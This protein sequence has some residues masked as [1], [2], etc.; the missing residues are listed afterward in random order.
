MVL[1]ATGDVLPQPAAGW[2]D[3]AEVVSVPNRSYAHAVNA[4]FAMLDGADL[5]T[6]MNDDVLVEPRTFADLL[7]ALAAHPG[8]GLS[9][10]I[11]LTAGGRPQDLGVPYR[12]AYARARKS[13]SGAAAVAWLAGCLVVMTRQAYVATGGLDETF[14]FTNE[15]LD[16]SLRARA[17]GYTSLL[18]DTE[19]THLGGTSTPRHPAFHV[20]GRRGGYLITQR[21]L[22]PVLAAAH[23]AYLVLEGGVGAL[24]GPTKSSRAAHRG[25]ARMAFTGSWRTGPFGPSLDDR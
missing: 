10:P 2:P 22:P 7:S 3:G 14:R 23:R 6:M 24:L 18:V 17:L 1:V 11:P 20:E 5:L 9:G 4:G 21:H 13:P 8:A 16:L 19:V 15:D 25:V 12:L